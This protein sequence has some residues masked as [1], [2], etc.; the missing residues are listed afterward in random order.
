[1]EVT[2][3]ARKSLTIK[4]E[5]AN[6]TKAHVYEIVIDGEN[7]ISVWVYDKDEVKVEQH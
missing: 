2:E 5:R 1:M 7:I 6:F 4:K 3:I